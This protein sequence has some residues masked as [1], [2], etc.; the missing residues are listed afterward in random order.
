MVCTFGDQTDI[1]WYKKH[2]LPLTLS[3]GLDGKW[4]PQ[5]GI[6]AGLKV[7]DA[8]KTILQALKEKG[9]L[10]SQKPISHNVNVHDR[11]KKEIEYNV[12]T[13]WFVNILEHKEQFLKLA[14]EI[15]WH[16]TFMKSRYVNW[17]Q[18][19]KWDWCI[20]RQRL[21]G[22]PFPAWHCADCKKVILPALDQLP[23]DP[24]ESA[25]TGTARAAL[26]WL[27]PM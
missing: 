11:C 24:Q 7:A 22:I 3:I 4:L 19:V 21:F 6:L 26:S 16:P 23:I 9:L 10:V 1:H 25:Y 2:K 8:R 17:V 15:I 12:L 5:T 27:I 20:S 14:D 13:Q 18:N